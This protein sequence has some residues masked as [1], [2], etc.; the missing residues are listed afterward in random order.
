MKRIIALQGKGS[1][2]KTTTI[3]LL[4][5][6]LE[7]NGYTPVPGKYRSYGSDFRDIFEKSGVRIGLTSSGDTYDLVTTRLKELVADCCDIC[8]CACRTSDR[9][10]PGT[11]AA[12][13]RFPD[14]EPVYLNKT[15]A[16]G[17][18]ARNDVNKLDA[19]RLYRLI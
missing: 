8:V 2:G 7:E 9:L 10:P 1:S 15:Y 11:I 13:K 16:D 3:K 6:I 19:E 4:P 14:Y 18:S 12:T 17:D 5:A